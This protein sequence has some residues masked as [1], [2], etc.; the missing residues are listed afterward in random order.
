MISPESDE[1][2]ALGRSCMDATKLPLQGI[3][4]LE[5]CTF[6][7][8]ISWTNYPD[9]PCFSGSLF[10]IKFFLFSLFSTFEREAIDSNKTVIKAMVGTED[11]IVELLPS[12]GQLESTQRGTY[13]K[14][15]LL[16]FIKYI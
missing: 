11:P 14:S 2:E 9:L 13:Y 5:R 4:R 1:L 12:A 6:K 10:H 16:I 7:L 3:V 8:L 15:T